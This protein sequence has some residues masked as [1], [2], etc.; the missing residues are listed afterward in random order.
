MSCSVF[1]Q[2]RAGG[3]GEL[4]LAAN[5]RGQ[6]AGDMLLGAGG[7]EG[8]PLKVHRGG[9]PDRSL[10]QAGR[11]L[12]REAGDLRTEA[13]IGA[14]A[15]KLF[16]ALGVAGLAQSRGEQALVGNGEVAELGEPLVNLGKIL[17][18]NGGEEAD[19][20]RGLA[21]GRKGTPLA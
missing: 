9:R 8:A 5:E 4:A 17:R 13:G 12:I 2:S 10:G 11:G 20:E 16:A 6:D 15:E 3:F 14:Q 1:G 19:R 21:G 7:D 18:E